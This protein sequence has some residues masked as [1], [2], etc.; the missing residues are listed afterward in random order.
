MNHVQRRRATRRIVVQEYKAMLG[1]EICGQ[2]YNP[3]HLSF[4]HLKD[5]HFNIGSRISNA[6]WNKLLDEIA[7][8]MVVCHTCHTKIHNRKDV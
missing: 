2:E 7:K 3:A 1:C 5:K 8:C 6:G 4:H